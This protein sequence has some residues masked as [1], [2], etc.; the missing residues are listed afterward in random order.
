MDTKF[1]LNPE[2]LKVLADNTKTLGQKLYAISKYCSCYFYNNFEREPDDL[3]KYEALIFAC[4]WTFKVA[5]S[6]Y[7]L[8]ENTQREIFM[9]LY[10]D[11]DQKIQSKVIE[12]KDCIKLFATRTE[13]YLK[14]T[15]I[16]HS[17]NYSFNPILDKLYLSPLSSSSKISSIPFNPMEYLKLVG[18]FTIGL[19]NYDKVVKY[20]IKMF[21]DT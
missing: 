19:K 2:D 1:Y 10:S 8:P 5:S 3:E 20:T 7:R 13:L 17:E 15:N 6:L 16:M 21:E 11:A 12:S 14:E 18:I 4:F 9:E